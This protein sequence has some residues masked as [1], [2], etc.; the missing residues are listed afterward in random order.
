MADLDHETAGGPLAELARAPER[1]AASRMLSHARLGLRAAPAHR[2]AGGGVGIVRA[3]GRGD[4]VHAAAAL[5]R[6]GADLERPRRRRPAD[7]HRRDAL[8][9]HDGLRDR[10]GRRHRARPCDLAREARPLVLRSDHLGRLPDAEDRLPAG[11]DA[12]ARRLRRVEDLDG[13]AGRDLPGGDR[14]RDRHPRGRARAALVGAQHG[15]RRAGNPLADRLPGGAAADHHRAAG[16]ACR[17]LSSLR[18]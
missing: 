7:E 6:A 8:S 5:G 11:D 12:L 2:R 9:R 17:S 14:D 3:L 15:R 16:G 13:G 18:W 1:T 10:G 4:A